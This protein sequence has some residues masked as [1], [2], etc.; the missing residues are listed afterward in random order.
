MFLENETRHQQGGTHR[1]E[2]KNKW[3]VKGKRGGVDHIPPSI[4]T[5]IFPKKKRNKKGRER[6][7]IQNATYHTI[8]PIA[9]IYRLLSLRYILHT[10]IK[11]RCHYYYYYYIIQNIAK[12]FFIIITLLYFKK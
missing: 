1:C 11:R 6:L 10:E 9:I 5:T 7:S 8:S 12:A 2:M 3:C 4:K